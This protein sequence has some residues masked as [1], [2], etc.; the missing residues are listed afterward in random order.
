MGKIKADGQMKFRTAVKKGLMKLDQYSPHPVLYAFI[1]S[2]KEKSVFD[3]AIRESGHYLEF[4]MGGSTLRALQ[5]SKAVIYTVESSPAW[6][7]HMRGYLLIRRFEKTRLHVFP[8]DIGPVRHWGYPS[9]D[10]FRNEYEAYSSKVFHLIDSRL[11]DLALIDGRFRVACALKTILECHGNAKIRILIHDFWERPQYHVLLRYLDVMK[12]VDSI[13]LF[14]I[15][16]DIDLKEA[17]KDYEDYKLT[18]E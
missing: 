11:V 10:A 8:V 17:E 1:M 3:E 9:S 15:K 16:R 6:I 18:P 2:R 7:D 14:S 4:G 12:R 5:K 13:G